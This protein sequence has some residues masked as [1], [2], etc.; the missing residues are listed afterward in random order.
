MRYFWRNTVVASLVGAA[1][2]VTAVP[3][4]PASA[5]STSDDLWIRFEGAKGGQVITSLA[6]SGTSSVTVSIVTVGRGR[7]VARK[8]AATKTKTADYPAYDGAPGGDRAVV[9][10]VNKGRTD[11]LEP[12]WH[13]FTLGVDARLDATNDG[14]PA[15]NGN[16][17]LQRGR[18]GDRVQYKL[19][20]D[21]GRFSCRVKGRR[22]TRL[23]WSSLTLSPGDWYR[24]RCRRQVLSS[25]DRLVLRV[26][27]IGKGGT[28][29]PATRTASG[30]GSLGS[31][32]FARTKPISIGGKLND[33]LTVSD[34][35]D[36]FNGR[37]DNAFLHI[38]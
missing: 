27:S 2:L 9:A 15:D 3:P 8:S 32:N 13:P 37:L 24:A 20:I 6:N 33:D 31:L 30:I 11:G 21:E 12:L 7:L 14:S 38:G 10:V 34:A 28:L 22:G 29:G 4:G 5:K 1:V 23:V 19:Q 25:G 18:F 35:S 36:Q 26:R 16:N 17:V